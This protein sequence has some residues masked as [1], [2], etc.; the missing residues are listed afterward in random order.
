[1]I[2]KGNSLVHHRTEFDDW[3]SLTI[4]IYMALTGLRC[5]GRPAGHFNTVDEQ[6][7]LLRSRGRSSRGPRLL[8]VWSCSR[9]PVH[10]ALS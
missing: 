3:R 2:T 9:S 4:G 10:K 6:P 7:G 1:M 8:A 5:H